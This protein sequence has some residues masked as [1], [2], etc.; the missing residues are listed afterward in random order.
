MSTIITTRV[1]MQMEVQDAAWQDSTSL[2]QVIKSGRDQA[3]G[4]FERLRM[5]ALHE[6]INIHLVE[7]QTPVIHVEVAK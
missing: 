1:V 6:R 3:K 7:I 5:A 2:A 4:T